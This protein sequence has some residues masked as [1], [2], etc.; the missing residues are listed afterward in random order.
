MSTARCPYVGRRP[1]RWELRVH[2]SNKPR[3]PPPVLAAIVCAVMLGGCAQDLEFDK[4]YGGYYPPNSANS[5]TSGSPKRVAK[6][7]PKATK[8]D[9]ALLEAPPE[10]DCGGG[11]TPGRSQTASAAD[12][13]TQSI[14]E[15]AGGDPNAE[16]AARIKVEYER[17]CYRQAEE[18]MRDRVKQ[19]QASKAA[20][21]AE[22]SA[23]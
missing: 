5:V 13:T 23:R 2:N 11:K 20:K 10:P 18:R 4:D 1:S 17:E 16:L 8:P 9:R 14:P 3:R 7:K 19:L 21:G 12:L 22:S 15:G 6:A